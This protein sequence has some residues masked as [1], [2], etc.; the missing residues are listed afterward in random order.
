MVK[1]SHETGKLSHLESVLMLTKAHNDLN[2]EM[3]SDPDFVGDQY[4]LFVHCLQQAY[5]HGKATTSTQVEHK[6]GDAPWMT[7][8]R[9]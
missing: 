5:E 7:D 1:H 4:R 6:H 2:I 9:K 3:C 8:L